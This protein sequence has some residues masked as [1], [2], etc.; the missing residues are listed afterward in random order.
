LGGASWLGLGFGRRGAQA[1]RV[2]GWDSGRGGCLN[3][4]GSSACGPGGGHA[5][6]GGRLGVGLCPQSVSDLWSG[7][8]GGARP[9]ATADGR[10]RRWA[11]ARPKLPAGCAPQGGGEAA[12]GGS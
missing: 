3:R 12:D 10:P 9:S 7:M 5:R 2:H 6:V 4:S 8:T 11:A 1:A